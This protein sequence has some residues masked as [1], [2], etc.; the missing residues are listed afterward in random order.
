MANL[1]NNLL[2][3]R[4]I[5]LLIGGLLVFGIMSLTVVKTGKEQLAE[6]S[7]EL[8]TS[9]YEAERLLGD[10][11]AQLENNDYT[12][13]KATLETLFNHQPGSAEAAE[14]KILLA[15]INTAEATSEARW[16]AAKPQIKED[17]SEAM[18]TQLRTESEEERVDM[19]ADLAKTIL[20]A[21]DDA[22]SDVRTEWEEK[23]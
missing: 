15:S 12:E 13:S 5:A 14:G 7:S 6:V 11:K 20:Q 3:N 10:A 1:K 23:S 22:K 2:V 4:I 18:A 16:E 19:E 9:L 17:W 21:W 8:N